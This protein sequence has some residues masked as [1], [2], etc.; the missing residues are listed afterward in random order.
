VTAADTFDLSLLQ[1]AQQGDLRLGG[2]SPTSSEDWCAPGLEA[3]EPRC[4]AP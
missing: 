1:Y 3:A 4:T 2:R